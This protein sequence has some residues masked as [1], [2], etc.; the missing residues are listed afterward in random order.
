VVCDLRDS[1][2]VKG[3][4]D[5]IVAEADVV[6]QNLRP[7][8]VEKLGIDGPTLLALKPSL[9]YCNLGAFGREGPLK[10]QTGL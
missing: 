5:F 8:Q 10:G 9:I 2:D 3:L 4:I 7:G 1:D 6:I